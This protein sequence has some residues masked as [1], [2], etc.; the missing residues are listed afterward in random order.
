MKVPV[1]AA[2]RL[3]DL[4]AWKDLQRNGCEP[5]G[6]MHY[7]PA[8]TPASSPGPGTPRSTSTRASTGAAGSD[9]EVMTLTPAKL[10]GDLPAKVPLPVTARMQSPESL[11]LE[12]PPGLLHP[13]EPS[14][15][16]RLPLEPPPGLDGP[17]P[18]GQQSRPLQF[19][20]DF[21]QGFLVGLAAASA[22]C[23]ALSDLHPYGQAPLPAAVAAPETLLRAV[24]APAPI[25][26]E[27]A[28]T[29]PARPGGLTCTDSVGGGSDVCWV[30]EGRRLDS[31]D[32]GVVSPPFNL[33]IY[34]RVARGGRCGGDFRRTGGWGHVELKCAVQLPQGAARMVF[35]IGVGSNAPRGPVQHDFSEQSC[36]GLPKDEAEWDFANAVEASGT[37]AVRLEVTPC[38]AEF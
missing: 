1:P 23:A 6:R 16:P 18:L 32:K 27:E 30:V 33:A 10:V 29:H 15:S 11:S 28:L 31:R 12:P 9:L 37:F 21:Q 4:A 7:S 2:S 14:L 13:L 24:T 35:S 25:A 20:R 22:R 5:R 3:A 26:P 34:P 38:D 8:S 19:W 36:A 17:G